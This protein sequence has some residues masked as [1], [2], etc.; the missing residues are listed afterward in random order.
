[1]QTHVDA[2]ELGVIQ[3]AQSVFHA[4]SV[5][6]LDDSNFLAAIIEHVSVDNRASTTSKVLQVLPGSATV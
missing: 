2:I 1:V 3:L 5:L 6:V 4:I